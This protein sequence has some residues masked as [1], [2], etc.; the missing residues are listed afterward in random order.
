MLRCLPAAARIRTPTGEVA[1]DRLA[2]GDL[3]MTLDAAGHAVPAPVVRV[4]SLPVTGPHELVAVT[5]AD[6]RT[7]RASP[8]HPTSTGTLLGA[9]AAGDK[10]DGSPIVSITRVPFTG[11]ATW[12]LLPAGA[13]GAYWADGVL[14][15]STLR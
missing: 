4:H 1:V 5:L 11:D 8:D 3:V 10:L 7:L 9:L 14:V 13:T 12:D 15:G 2:V 6:G